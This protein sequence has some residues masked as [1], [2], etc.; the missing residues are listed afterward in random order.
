MATSYE[1]TVEVPENYHMVVAKL[2][3]YLRHEKRYNR[4]IINEA[5]V[6][7][8]PSI[9]YRTMTSGNFRSV[10]EA[11]R[12]QCIMIPDGTQIQIRSECKQKTQL[13]DWG[14]NKD[15]VLKLKE[16]LQFGMYAV[17][18]EEKQKGK[19]NTDPTQKKEKAKREKPVIFPVSCIYCG[20][21][22]ALEK[23]TSGSIY[24]FEDRLEFWVIRKKFTIYMDEITDNRISTYQQ[25][26]Q[27]LTVTRI[28]LFG[29][30][31]AAM[32]QKSLYQQNYLQVTYKEKGVES[33]VIF[34]PENGSKSAQ[35]HLIRI[36][37]EL[38]RLRKARNQNEY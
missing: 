28:A 15:N 21:H 35:N 8:G 38:I 34:C 22:E 30:F 20:G 4:T 16:F 5:E 18:P 24:L 3:A 6:N 11:I 33:C 29:I 9:T 32:P 2:T 23:E 12:I 7:G 26:L 1:E 25:V 27:R 17:P 37:A 10:G 31:A 19:K 36:N 14:V 13:F